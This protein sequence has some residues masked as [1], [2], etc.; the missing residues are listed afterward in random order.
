MCTPQNLW[1]LACQ[2]WRWHIQRLYRLSRRFRGQARSHRGLCRSTALCTPQNLWE[3][4]CQRWRWHIQRLY[5]LSRRF[6]GQARSHRGLCRSAI[7]ARHKTRG[8]WLASD[9]VGTS[10]VFID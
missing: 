4:A 10:N 2:R 9:G 8:S 1:E 6:R 7:G 5:Q 3:L